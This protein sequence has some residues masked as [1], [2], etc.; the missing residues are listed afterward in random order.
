MPRPTH[1]E[2]PIQT[3]TLTATCKLDLFETLWH[4][5]EPT[6]PPRSREAGHAPRYCRDR[7]STSAIIAGLAAFPLVA[8]TVFRCRPPKLRTSLALA[9]RSVGA[10]GGAAVSLPGFPSS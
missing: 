6:C 2:R 9:S 1:R 8:R 10:A 5:P 4:H 3:D 7:K